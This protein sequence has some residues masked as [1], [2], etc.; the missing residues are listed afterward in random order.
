MSSFGACEKTRK[1]HESIEDFLKVEMFENHM[2]LPNV[3]FMEVHRTNIKRRGAAETDI[4]P[5]RPIHVYLLRYRDK[6]K[7]IKHAARFFKDSP[8]QD[9]KIFISDDVFKAFREKKR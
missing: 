8:L 1:N 5:P 3:E 4:P 7:I 2:G 6:C 9:S